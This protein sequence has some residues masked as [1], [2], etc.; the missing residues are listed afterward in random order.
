MS[1]YLSGKWSAYGSAA[2]V[3]LPIVRIFRPNNIRRPPRSPPRSRQYLQPVA[4]PSRLGL[5]G[6]SVAGSPRSTTS[7]Y[8]VGSPGPTGDVEHAPSPAETVALAELN[9]EI[10]EN[11]DSA[12]T[13]EYCGISRATEEVTDAIKDWTDNVDSNDVDIVDEMLQVGDGAEN[14]NAITRALPIE[15]LYQTAMLTLNGGAG[16]AHLRVRQTVHSRRAPERGG[17]MSI[18]PELG[19]LRE[20]DEAEVAEFDMLRDAYWQA[21]WRELETVGVPVT[22]DVDPRHDDGHAVEP[23]LGDRTAAAV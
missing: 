14:P 13:R 10:A 22:E 9:E 7:S 2:N 16:H 17:Y 12:L 3:E 21:Q 8:A 5:P 19:T 18:V 23:V 1:D 11:H 20:A 15:P 4:G 6:G